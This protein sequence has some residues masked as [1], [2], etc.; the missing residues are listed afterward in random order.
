MSFLGWIGNADSFIFTLNPKM[1]CLYSTG[2]N[3]N[4]MF[5]DQGSYGL[6]YVKKMM[7][8]IGT[9][10][11]IVFQISRIFSEWEEKLGDSVLEFLQIWKL[12][13]IMKM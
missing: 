11:I 10:I 12:W 6:G 3:E 1:A 5:L 2:Q 7:E 8:L 9:M 4:F 13:T